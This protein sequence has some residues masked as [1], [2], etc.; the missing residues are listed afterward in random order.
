MSRGPGPRDWPLDRLERLA[1]LAAD[2]LSA[3]QM[4]DKMHMSRNAILGMCYRRGIAITRQAEGRKRRRVRSKPRVEVMD[5]W[6]PTYASGHHPASRGLGYALTAP[7]V[8]LPPGL[9]DLPA[10][11]TA[12]TAVTIM[13]LTGQSC[14]WPVGGEPNVNMLYCGATKATDRLSFCPFHC[15]MAYRPRGE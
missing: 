2:G 12:A 14:R 3:R 1:T 15:R 11:P 13:G 5:G 6:R 4:A 8:H 9:M 7:A 10:E